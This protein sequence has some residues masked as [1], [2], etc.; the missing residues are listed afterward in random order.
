[1]VIRCDWCCQV[2]GANVTDC[3]GVE[4]Y[5]TLI[6][7]VWPWVDAVLYA[8]IPFFVILVLNSLIIRHLIVARHLR[9]QL[10]SYCPSA[11]GS[12]RVMTADSEGSPGTANTRLVVTLLV[13]SFAFLVT[14]LPRSAV[15]IVAAF[16]QHLV[17]ESYGSCEQYCAVK[18]SLHHKNP[19]NSI[20]LTSS[21]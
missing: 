20:Q 1:M 10:S 2:P 17:C 3:R 14:T 11:G 5:E 8:F 21:I 6:A 15:L 19:N 13:V 18:Q 4:G 16:I 7:D 9:H 12:R